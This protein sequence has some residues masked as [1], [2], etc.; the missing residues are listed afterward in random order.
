MTKRNMPKVPKS[1][2]KPNIRFDLPDSV[3]DKWQANIKASSET[4]IPFRSMKK[5]AMTGGRMMG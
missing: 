5:L 2:N 4:D 1:L 3:L